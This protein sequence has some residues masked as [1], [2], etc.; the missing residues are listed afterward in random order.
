[1]NLQNIFKY[2]AILLFI[3]AIITAILEKYQFALICAFF[4]VMVASSYLILLLFPNVDESDENKKSSIFIDIIIGGICFIP[5]L[6]FLEIQQQ[7]IKWAFKD[8]PKQEICGVFERQETR[9]SGKSQT[10]YYTV[11]NYQ[12]KQ[13]LEFIRVKKYDIY[14]LGDKICVKYAIDERWQNT[15]YIYSV[16]KD[17]QN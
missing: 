3:I 5:L 17:F 4:C 2:L 10:T 7:V 15:P 1:M 8:K 13:S 6:T 9:S 14:Q 12:T 16:T 11:Y